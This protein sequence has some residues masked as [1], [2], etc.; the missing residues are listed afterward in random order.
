M[1]LHE[2]RLTNLSNWDGADE[3]GIFQLIRM[4]FGPDASAGERAKIAA[5]LDFHSGGTGETPVLH[6]EQPSTSRDASFIFGS[7]ASSR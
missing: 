3:F 2:Q 1:P 7:D 6:C 5:S 4:A